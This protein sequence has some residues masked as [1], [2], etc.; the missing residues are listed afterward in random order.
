VSIVVIISPE[1]R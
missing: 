1:E